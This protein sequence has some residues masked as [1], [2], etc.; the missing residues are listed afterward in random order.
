MLVPAALHC[1]SHQTSQT[2]YPTTPRI[3]NVS[4]RIL[5]YLRFETSATTTT[6]RTAITS[7]SVVLRPLRTPVV[8]IAGAAGGTV[9]EPAGNGDVALVVPGA[10]AGVGDGVNGPAAGIAEGRLT[11]GSTVN[12]VPPSNAPASVNAWTSY[13]PSS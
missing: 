3:S 9:D 1:E 12:V 11:A 13:V 10:G 2:A 5:C 4:S 7:Q 6:A 8:P